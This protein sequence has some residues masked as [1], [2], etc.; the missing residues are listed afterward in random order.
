[1]SA[2]QSI[3]T[4]VIVS[5]G[6][7]QEAD[8]DWYKFKNSAQ[9]KKILVQL[10]DLPADY[11]VKLF[12]ST[13]VQL[14]VSQNSGLADER[15]AYNNGKNGTYYI[16]VYSAAGAFSQ[17]QCYSLKATISSTSYPAMPG[18]TAVNELDIPLL[19]HVYPNPAKN[20][21]NVEYHAVSEGTLEVKLYTIIGASMASG[22]YPVMKGPNSYQLDVSRL[23]KGVY[24][25][26][27]YNGLEKKIVKLLVE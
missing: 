14:G 8:L 1:L 5:A 3:S 22:T 24:L 11:D 23:Q 13:G 21:V 15:I 26:Y 12:S 10:Y 4:G 9:Q 25:L 16:E 17:E 18:I 7:P 6:I 27:L 19:F 20:I 2:A